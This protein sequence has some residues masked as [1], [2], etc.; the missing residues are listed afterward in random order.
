M[1]LMIDSPR[2]PG[3][4]G[5]RGHAGHHGV[6][7]F[8]A[9]PVACDADRIA[10]IDK[11]GLEAIDGQRT[12]QAGANKAYDIMPAPHQRSQR[13]AT[14]GACGTKETH[15]DRRA[16]ASGDHVVLVQERS[17]PMDMSPSHVGSPPSRT[18]EPPVSRTKA[19]PL[20]YISPRKRTVGFRPNSVE[21]PPRLTFV[22]Q[23]SDRSR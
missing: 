7:P 11:T 10:H 14:D 8:A 18:M 15:S 20:R 22:Q 17:P 12:A 9:K 3:R 16:R 19:H 5:A 2:V 4:A 1:C 23:I 13:R 21:S 6:E